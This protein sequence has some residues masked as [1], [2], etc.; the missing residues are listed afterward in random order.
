VDRELAVLAIACAFLAAWLWLRGLTPKRISR[1]LGRIDGE[2]LEAARVLGEA[3]PLLACSTEDLAALCLLLDRAKWGW[4]VL[5]AGPISLEFH[6]GVLGS[7]LVAKRSAAE[8]AEASAY[9]VAPFRSL[10]RA[11]GAEGHAGE[12]K[13]GPIGELAELAGMGAGDVERALSLLKRAKLADIVLRKRG[14][15]ARV[16]N[17]VGRSALSVSRRSGRGRRI[18]EYDLDE[19][20]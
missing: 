15:E 9:D 20:G 12:Q 10:A 3:A 8:R 13:E 16:Y 7:E 11:L 5:E 14:V 17:Y 2:L 18:V 19:V 4:V 6:K 1:L